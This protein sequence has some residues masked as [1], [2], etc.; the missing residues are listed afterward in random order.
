MEH[1]H[2]TSVKS[3]E[4]GGDWRRAN[5]ESRVSAGGGESY[6]GRETNIS[7]SG[8]NSRSGVNGGT[9]SGSGAVINE[10]NIL[11]SVESENEMK[12]WLLVVENLKVMK[13][14][15]VRMRGLRGCL[16]RL[17]RSK[18]KMGWW[19]SLLHLCIQQNTR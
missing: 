12:Y 1:R 18:M 14:R 4:E 16:R 2:N 19:N 17:G 6:S 7:G 9:S 8:A 13:V 5:R 11:S 3:G 15:R 10:P